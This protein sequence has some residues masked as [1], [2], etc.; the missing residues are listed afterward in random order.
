MENTMSF[1]SQSQRHSEL[2]SSAR[3][4]LQSENQQISPAPIQE[5]RHYEM[6]L[7]RLDAKPSP[8][9]ILSAYSA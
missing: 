8:Q 3:A 4:S 2:L 1:F 6:L 9:E 7:K 5:N